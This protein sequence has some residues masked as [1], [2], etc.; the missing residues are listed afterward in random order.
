MSVLMAE[1]VRDQQ[2][3]ERRAVELLHE[4]APKSAAEVPH[5][6]DSNGS[7]VHSGEVPVIVLANNEDLQIDREVCEAGAVGYLVRAGI[8]GAQLERAI[9][10][11]RQRKRTVPESDRQSEHR[12]ARIAANAPGIGYQ[13]VLHSDGSFEFPYISEG[14]RRVYD[15]D[16]AQFQQNS[17]LFFQADPSRRPPIVFDFNHGISAYAG[18]VKMDGARRFADR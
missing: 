3:R 1:E 2:G 9:R 6:G 5:R 14:S 11:A 13:F 8:R 7:Q 18:A 4:V 10:Y 17:Q 15:I 16:P 12:H